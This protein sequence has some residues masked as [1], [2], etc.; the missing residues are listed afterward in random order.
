MRSCPRCRNL[1]DDDALICGRDG[2]RLGFPDPLLGATVAHWQLDAPR[3]RGGM[4]TV[5]VGTPLAG[6][7]P[8]AVKVLASRFVNRPDL[9]E[10]FSTEAMA[11]AK[12]KHPNIVDFI[13][14]GVLPDGRPYYVMELLD[15][16]DLASYLKRIGWISAGEAIQMI[17]QVMEGI[18]AAHDAGVIHRDLKPENLFVSRR[19]DGSRVMKVLD[20]GVA[21][22]TD[23]A[24]AASS[25]PARRTL[26]GVVVG[27]GPYMAPEQA[28]G[29]VHE[30]GPATDMWAL[31][32]VLYLMLTGEY[33]FAQVGNM[34]AFHRPPNPPSHKAPGL[35]PG[36]DEIL[37]DLLTINPL[38][39]AR[40]ARAVAHAL[41]ALAPALPPV[42]AADGVHMGLSQSNSGGAVMAIPT[43]A[44]VVPP[45]EQPRAPELPLRAPVDPPGRPPEPTP[46]LPLAPPPPPM[47]PTSQPMGFAQGPT[48]PVP[49]Q[50]HPQPDAEININR[51]PGY[52]P[53]VP[54]DAEL[55]PAMAAAMPPMRPLPAAPPRPQG[56]FGLGTPAATK[57][58]S[59]PP[60]VRGNEKLWTS[61]IIRIKKVERSTSQMLAQQGFDE[62]R[63][64]WLGPVFGIVVFL[65]A[66]GGLIWFAL[67]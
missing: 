35:P 30:I 16:E 28:A 18:S 56:G 48:Q 46:L 62:P 55:P 33:P 36:I 63:S 29:R 22:L 58:A 10:R 17:A 1:Y 31:G 67:H 20:F 2:E 65:G 5:Y 43:V 9:I 59:S 66:V 50:Q 44:T 8:V 26:E 40:H 60:S 6:G 14:N 19:P 23:V 27:S 32:V 7:S 41:R 57:A 53:T 51:P 42:G 64:S 52:R 61:Q 11:A 49:V 47:L 24:R 25:G 4:G 15:G 37:A 39:R 21:K 3:G 38:N 45:P 13:A 34:P 12:I 54:P